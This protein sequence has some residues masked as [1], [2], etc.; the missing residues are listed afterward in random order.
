[1]ARHGL[2]VHS[3]QTSHLRPISLRDP[4]CRR[5]T[6]DLGSDSDGDRE[7]PIS[8]IPGLT[9]SGLGQIRSDSI[10]S[11]QVRFVFS[12]TSSSS[13]MS[14][15]SMTVEDL[16]WDR[17]A[18]SITA[19]CRGRAQGV[20]GPVTF[21]CHLHLHLHLA[22]PPFHTDATAQRQRQRQRQRRL[23]RATRHAETVE[24]GRLSLSP[25]PPSAPSKLGSLA[26]R[27]I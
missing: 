23:V 24:C 1:M 16:H 7:W 20:A 17:T 2:H 3:Q 13:S 15:S 10:G 14:S 8:S 19:P 22:P 5:P 25:R 9:G 18:A 26:I 12:Y 11:H 6:S 27:S 21:D 4:D